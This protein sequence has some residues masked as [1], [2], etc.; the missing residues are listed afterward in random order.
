MT[1]TTIPVNFYQSEE[2]C[3]ISRVALLV[4]YC[5]LEFRGSQAQRNQPT[6]QSAVQI[7]LQQLNLKTSAVS[8]ASRTD[9]GVNALGQVAHFDVATD[10][11][12]NVSNLASALN[13]VLPGSIAVRAV[14]LDLGRSFHARRDATAKW[15]RYKI[16]NSRN[17][18]VWAQHGATLHRPVLD[19]DLM[20]QAA[21]LILGE[22][23][24][25]SFKD[26]GSNVTHDF[27]RIEAIQVSRDGDFITVD[28]AANRFLYKM[29]RNIVGQLMVIGN[30]KNSLSPET[31][32]KVISERDRR[33]ASHSAPAEGLTLMSVHYQAPFNLF[34]KD[35]Y[36][37]QFKNILKPMESLQNENLFRKAS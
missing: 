18:S 9:A 7:A 28:V 31:I 14:Q 26:L 5:G 33:K 22:H 3:A 19:T 23:E 30:H 24:F 27:C 1:D 6:V 34:E 12:V 4:E 37:Q 35:V 15:Y 13:A 25:T 21:Q 8:F 17:R 16:Y 10:A 29:V 32:L 2:N 36:V 11:L 20:N